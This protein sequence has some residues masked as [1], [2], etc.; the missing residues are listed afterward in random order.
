[1]TFTQSAYGASV[2]VKDRG[3]P[4]TDLAQISALAIKELEIQ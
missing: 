2:A 3:D 1:V 4:L